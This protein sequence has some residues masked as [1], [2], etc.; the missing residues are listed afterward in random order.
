MKHKLAVKKKIEVFF[1]F[2]LKIEIFFL[3]LRLRYLNYLN[4]SKNI[5]LWIGFSAHTDVHLCTKENS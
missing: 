3:K 2:L 5:S 1:S 4:A